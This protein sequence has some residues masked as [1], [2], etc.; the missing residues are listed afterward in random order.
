[1]PVCAHP[2][3]PPSLVD[4]HYKLV[5]A[6]HALKLRVRDD[7]G[8]F[9]LLRV[10]LHLCEYVLRLRLRLVNLPLPL[11]LRLLL[12]NVLILL[13]QLEQ[14]RHLEHVL[15]AA[16][17]AQAV[18]QAHQGVLVLVRRVVNW[19]DQLPLH[20]FVDLLYPVPHYAFEGA[21]VVVRGE[22]SQLDSEI[23]GLDYRL[24]NL[25]VGLELHRPQVLEQEKKQ[26]GDP[27]VN[28]DHNKGD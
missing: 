23:L 8:R 1:M 27:N 22:S 14:I 9:V 6:A 17:V 21:D 12:Q 15:K 26:E 19:I 13:L 7:P 20:L 16:V 2:R 11:A 24:R 5:L 4:S 10:A 25:V 28:T 18:V 3:A